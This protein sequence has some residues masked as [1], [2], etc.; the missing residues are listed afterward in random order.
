MNPTLQTYCES[1]RCILNTYKQQDIAIGFF[2]LLNVS[3]VSSAVSLSIK[4][5]REHI[6]LQQS[7]YK[8]F[9]KHVH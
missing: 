2:N 7:Q 3:S 6:D 9:T 5:C 8:Y 1:V 4:I